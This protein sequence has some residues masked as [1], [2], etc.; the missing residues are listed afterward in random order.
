MLAKSSGRFQ[1]RLWDN[2]A[3]SLELF[4]GMSSLKACEGGCI[5][6]SISV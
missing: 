6:K 1:N 5:L 2:Q 4:S 3:Q